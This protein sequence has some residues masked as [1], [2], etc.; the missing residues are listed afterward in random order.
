[1]AWC[2]NRFS[3]SR[4]SSAEPVP[5]PPAPARP[6][7]GEAGWHK[8]ADAGA[9]HARRR[10]SGRECAMQIP[11]PRLIETL[12]HARGALV[13]LVLGASPVGAAAAASPPSQ[14]SRAGVVAAA[15]PVAAQAGADVLA[16]GGNAVDAAIA[17]SAALGVAEPFASG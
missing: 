3:S 2:R 10:A 1:G 13:V 14:A 8:T 11:G 9:S 5:N 4:R 12:G 15:H 16:Q 7:R 17:T 6:A